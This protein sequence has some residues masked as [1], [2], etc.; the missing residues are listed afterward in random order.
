LTGLNSKY[1]PTLRLGLDLRCLRPLSTIFQLYRGCQFYWWRKPEYREKTTDLPQVTNKLYHIMLHPVHLV[2]VGFK[3]TTLV[4]IGTDCIG[5]YKSIL[6]YDHDHDCPTQLESSTHTYLVSAPVILD[7]DL[8]LLPWA[9]SLSRSFSSHLKLFSTSLSND[10]IKQ[11][12]NKLLIE[13]KFP[14]INAFSYLIYHN[15]CMT[16]LHS[17]CY[18]PLISILG[19]LPYK[20]N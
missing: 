8:W 1:I 2:W 10:L 19:V 3:L 17:Y 6:R 20:N 9:P 12:K 14:H 16:F 18:V 13:L 5:S 11:I 7:T 4:V 15:K